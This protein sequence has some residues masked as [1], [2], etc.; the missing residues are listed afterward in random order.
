MSPVSG[1]QY[2]PWLRGQLRVGLEAEWLLAISQVMAGQSAIMYSGLYQQHQSPLCE[3][4]MGELVESPLVESPPGVGGDILKD[5]F[6]YTLFSISSP[7]WAHIS[8]H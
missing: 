1:S 4:P 8:I 5:F 7:L 2:L 3:Y 6:L